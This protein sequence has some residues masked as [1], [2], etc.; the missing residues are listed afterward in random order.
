MSSLPLTAEK[1]TEFEELNIIKRVDGPTPWV[2]P[3]IAIPKPNG[4]VRVCVDMRQANQAILR[5]RH[6]I[7]TL[8]E[9]L[10]E[11]KTGFK[12]GLSSD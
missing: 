10:Q 12:M 1:L 9:T 2:S 8:E 5:E 4:D 6:L 7:P 11:L 3:L